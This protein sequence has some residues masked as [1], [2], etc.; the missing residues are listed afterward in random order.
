M[1][2][3]KS[4]LNEKKIKLYPRNKDNIVAKRGALF[5]ID[6]KHAVQERGF[7]VAHIKTD[8][9]KIPNATPE[10]I[11]FV[12]DFGKRYGYTFEHEATYD[13]MC[14]VNNA[15]YIAKYDIP[16]RCMAKY[17]Y[18]PGDVQ[19]H[20]GAW[21]ATGAQ[22]QVPYVFKTLFS[23]EPVQFKDMCEV[24]SVTS[25][26]YL[27]MNERLPNVDEEERLLLKKLKQPDTS[28]Q[29]IQELEQ[30]IAR[31]H[32]YRFIGRVGQ[33]TPMLPACGAGIL[34]R[35]TGD[36]YSAPS[37]TKGYRFMESEMVQSLKLEDQI[38]L[39]FYRKLVDEAVQAISKYTDFE[40][41]VSPEPF[42]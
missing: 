32:N 36:K 24:Y 25:S 3:N 15:V 2:K 11:Q 27:D 29:E 6:L 19:D 14:L 39:G 10:I 17:G 7:T 38:D 21:T 23:Q 31:G 8:S 16:E 41:F 20:P 1:N 4:D 13:R 40:R 26:L 42:I 28:E 37:G 22:F 30:L 34:V 33:F 18:V 9:I 5:M 12:M 35:K